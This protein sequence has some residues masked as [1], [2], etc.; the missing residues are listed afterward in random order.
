MFN[1][2]YDF[3][4]GLDTRESVG[5]GGAIVRDDLG[6]GTVL[7]LAVILLSIAIFLGVFICVKSSW[8]VALVGVACMVTGYLYSD[9]PRPIAYTPY[10]E[11]IAGVF[12]GP[13][14]IYNELCS[15]AANSG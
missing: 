14:I 6:A 1:E 9:G 11:L 12:M 13:V 2:Y 10:G 7:Y 5:I 3:K 4:R 15:H 8:L